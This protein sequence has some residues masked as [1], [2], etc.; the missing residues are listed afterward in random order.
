MLRIVIVS[1]VAR[2]V[3]LAPVVGVSN[4]KMS[5]SL[6][7]LHLKT[8]ESNGF[9]TLLYATDHPGN[10]RLLGSRLTSC[11]PGPRGGPNRHWA[12]TDLAALPRLTDVSNAT[13]QQANGA[14]S[15][16]TGTQPGPVITVGAP[17]LAR[18]EPLPGVAYG[19]DQLLEYCARAIDANGYAVVVAPAAATLRYSH[20]AVDRIDGD[21]R[22][23]RA[24]LATPYVVGTTLALPPLAV[25]VAAALAQSALPGRSPGEAI[26]I[27]RRLGASIG[28]FAWLR[29]PRG[30]CQVSRSSRL[31]SYASGT[32]YLLNSPWGI[33]SPLH[34][35]LRPWSAHGATALERQAPLV[36]SACSRLPAPVAAGLD[37]LAR[38][39]SGTVVDPDP[40][41]AAY[42]GTERSATGVWIPDV[43]KVLATS[44]T[45]TV[46]RAADP[47]NRC[48]WC[49]EVN[50]HATCPICHHH[51]PLEARP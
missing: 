36:M 12:F 49:G 9:R 20:S 18:P 42:W 7:I 19:F 34:R 4:D 35:L 51:Q 37:A 40:S 33:A 23:V 47:S 39:N 25:A 41:E 6:L 16:P 32:G 22:R 21:V 2:Q 5:S 10:C 1:G 43:A 11:H 27:V 29:H 14:E 50:H 15:D 24:L 44:T 28:W 17:R 46:D 26:T 45:V 48:V 38:A 30:L 3:G 8:P 31:R 13:R